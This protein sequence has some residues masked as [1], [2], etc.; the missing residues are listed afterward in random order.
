M[1]CRDVIEVPDHERFIK[2][3]CQIIT[4]IY[5][6]VNQST[7]GTGVGGGV[8]M[9]WMK[10]SS[11]TP[12]SRGGGNGTSAAMATSTSSWNIMSHDQTFHYQLITEGIHYLDVRLKYETEIYD[13]SL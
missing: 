7:S 8:A 12:S 11:D 1:V 10:C 3:M 13:S 6:T 4:Q 9:Y 5:V 2:S